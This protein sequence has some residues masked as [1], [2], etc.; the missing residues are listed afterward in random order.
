MEATATIRTLDDACKEAGVSMGVPI[1]DPQEANAS[2]RYSP[3]PNWY[4]CFTGLD[5]PRCETEI[6]WEWVG[7]LPGVTTPHT[8]AAK[9]VHPEVTTGGSLLGWGHR[10]IEVKCNACGQAWVVHNFD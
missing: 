4:G 10:W 9:G 1:A 5:C 2:V 7:E 8:I 6:R 3:I